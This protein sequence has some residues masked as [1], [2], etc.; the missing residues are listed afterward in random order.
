MW[1]QRKL[2]SVIAP[3]FNEAEVV[4][5]FH[6]ALRPA[7]ES[8]PGVDFEIVF[9]DDGSSDDTLER[10]NQIAEQDPAVRVYSLSRNF[11]HQIALTAGLDAASGDAVIMMDSDLQH[12][13]A[14]I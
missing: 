11:G 2:V 4:G 1:T 5:L 10:L 6:A 3:C 12:P 9:V 14:L 8:R 13:P 7:L